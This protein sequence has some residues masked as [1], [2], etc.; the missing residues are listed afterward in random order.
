VLRGGAY[1]TPSIGA[2][3]QFRTSRA[4]VNIVEAT[5]GFRCCRATAP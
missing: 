3:C 5:N 2:T 4:A 1:D